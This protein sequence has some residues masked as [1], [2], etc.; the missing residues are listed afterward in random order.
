M[1]AETILNQLGGNLFIVMTGSKNFVK[2]ADNGIGMQ[3]RK[4]KSKASHLRITLTPNDTYTMEFI[5]C[6]SKDL[7]TLEKYEDVYN[8][9]LRGIFESATGMFTKI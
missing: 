4:N 6:T 5:K 8:T 9:E 3:L 2:V 7:K 1:I